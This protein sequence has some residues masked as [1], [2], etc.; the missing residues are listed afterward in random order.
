LGSLGLAPSPG[1]ASSSGA[2]VS[3]L[4]FFDEAVAELPTE[5]EAYQLSLFEWREWRAVFDAAAMGPARPAERTPGQLL[6]S[7]EAYCVW[8]A[9]LSWR[10]SSD[11][12]DLDRVAYLEAAGILRDVVFRETGPQ[13]ALPSLVV[14]PTPLEIRLAARP[15][16]CL[17]DDLLRADPSLTDRKL[18]SH[19]PRKK[20]ARMLAVLPRVDRR[21]A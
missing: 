18:L 7:A 3:L 1:S 8:R 2:V 16:A 9:G 21:R 19:L 13:L 5:F 10:P 20:L 14:P 6:K 15:R 4:R 17:I 12:W 11:R